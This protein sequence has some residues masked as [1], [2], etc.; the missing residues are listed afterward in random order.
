VVTA[1]FE[2]FL[3]KEVPRLPYGATLLIVTGVTTPQLVETLV[4]LRQKGRQI[5]LLSFAQQ[6]PPE[7]QGIRI[8][9]H[10]FEESKISE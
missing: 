7:M 2:R 6:P 1:P 4:K 5:T 3:I 9:H 8:F 10:P